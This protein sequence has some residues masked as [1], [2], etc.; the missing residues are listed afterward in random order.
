MLIQ[1]V[2]GRRYIG[3]AG[4]REGEQG[5]T[6]CDRDFGIGVDGDGAAQL[7]R[8]ELGD[9]RYPGGAADQQHYVQLVRLKLGG[10]QGAAQRLHGLADLSADH[11]LEL[12]TDQPYLGLDPGCEHRNGHVGIG[13]ERFFSLS[14]LP[15][16]HRTR[17]Q[18]GGIL[19][20]ELGQRRHRGQYVGEHRVIEI[21][22]T[23]LLQALGLA[24]HAEPSGLGLANH[25]RVE[26]PPT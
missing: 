23:Q 13:R 2:V 1:R 16:Q 8:D 3:G 26:G 18:H 17:S 14:A 21:R 24:Q 7:G 5:S 9:K 22:P 6:E 19:T 25:C 20:I 15:A 4:S 11:V 12:G 10:L